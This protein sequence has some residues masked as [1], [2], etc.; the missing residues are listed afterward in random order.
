MQAHL[1][2]P[3]GLDLGLSSSTNVTLDDSPATLPLNRIRY[4]HATHALVVLI[5]PFPQ[6]T[7]HESPPVVTALNLTDFAADGPLLTDHIPPRHAFKIWHLVPFPTH[8][9]FQLLC[10]TRKSICY[11]QQDRPAH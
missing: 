9:K 5:P 1:V 7:A 10:P 2:V 8:G 11:R 6:C 4:V 3:S